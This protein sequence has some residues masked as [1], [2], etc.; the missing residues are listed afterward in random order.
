MLMAPSLN[1]EDGEDSE[2]S[3]WKQYSLRSE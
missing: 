1:S 2:Y 3:A